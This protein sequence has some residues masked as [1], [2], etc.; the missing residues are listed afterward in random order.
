MV[1]FPVAGTHFRK[2]EVKNLAEQIEP[3]FLPGVLDLQLKS[4]VLLGQNIQYEFCFCPSNI[5][6][7]NPKNLNEHNPTFKFVKY[8]NNLFNLTGFSS[9]LDQNLAIY[10][11]FYK[12]S[13]SEVKK[14][15]FL[16]PGGET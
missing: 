13:E 15:K 6:Y 14:I 1:V 7:E 8:L 2:R 9:F 12:E 10:T 4:T 3:D 5:I 11:V 16:Q